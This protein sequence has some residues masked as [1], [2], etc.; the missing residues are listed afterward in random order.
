MSVQKHVEEESRFLTE[1][2]FKMSF[3]AEYH[4]MENQLAN[5]TATQT[6]VQVYNC[7]ALHK[8]LIGPLTSTLSNKYSFNKM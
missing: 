5:K 6:I 2:Y 1:G 8:E 3:M 4:V 7:F